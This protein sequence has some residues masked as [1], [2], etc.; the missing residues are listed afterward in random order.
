M[1][2]RGDAVSR[3]RSQES[4]MNQ[5]VMDHW[6]TVKR[7]HQ[8][9]LD[10]DPSKRAAFVDELCGGDEALRREVHSLLTYATDAE[11]FLE[12][13]AVDIATSSSS[14]RHETTLVG[15]TVSHY[16]VLSMLGA[17]G[18]GEVY[19]ARD[20]RLDRTVA[21]KI[22]PG[23][24]AA[25]PERMQRFAREAKA[26]SAL[27]H[28]NVA[29]IY[30]VGESDGISFIVMEHVEGETLLP[31]ISR[32]MTPPE[33]VDIAVQAADAL[34]L[35]HAKGI[36]HRDIKPANLMLTHRGVV[37]VLDF[38][39]AKVARSDEGSLNGDWT[40][41]P[42]TAVGSVV[43]S[44]PYMSPEQIVGGDV[45]SRSDVFNL[46]VVIYQMA[47]GQ[48]PFSGSTRAELMDQILHAAPEPMMRLNPDLP[49][50]L[51]RITLKCLD[52]RRDDRYQSGRELLTD[53]WPLKRQLD[54][55]VARAMPDAV[56]L[57]LLRRSA[58]HPGAAAVAPA[59]ADDASITDVPRASEAL[60][61]VARGWAHLRSASF[62]ELPAAVSSF[63]AATVI[64]PTYAAAYA[65][66]AHAKIDQAN[67]RHVLVEAFGEAKAAALRAVALD[68][69]SADAQAALG[70]VMLV[71]EWDW[72]AAERSF[73]RAL[74][75]NP[76]HAEAYLH[77]GTLMEALGNL[78]RGFQLKLKGLE[79]DS[80][81]AL[82][83]VQIAGSFWFQRRY[84]D[85]IVW[86]NK[87]L[88]RN[89][90][91]L[92]ARG[93]LAAAYW[94]MGDLERARKLL[95]DRTQL[96]LGDEGLFLAVNCAQA[97]DLDAAF[98][99]LQRLIDTRDFAVIHLA[100][101]PEWDSLRADPRFNECLAR[102][103]L[104]PVL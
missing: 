23:A 72:I 37:K 28:P 84:D 57:E 104:R 66:L 12:Q 5:P 24:L 61:L 65:G 82:A 69:E 44:G 8:S 68:H 94:K 64:D 80:T 26:A 100:V 54:A 18:M 35:A 74:A 39:V 53:L 71:A 92:A 79:C 90:Q 21:L 101:A 43:G 86:A 93:E 103:K 60:E 67:D 52:K 76:N 32:R 20:S 73:Q 14:E 70:L 27:N 102:M 49:S 25:D 13:P 36:T 88:D 97:G 59:G 9:A 3:P 42:V 16:Q 15:R 89:P 29:T 7:I 91:H 75:I 33:V 96:D 34:D 19:L 38:G 17:G 62:F 40:V 6:T 51:E 98:E 47:T 10:V 48:L 41:E 56:R 11:S 78:E 83:H 50:E 4:D 45:D 77:Y 30:D 2:H 81:S 46:G 63:Q 99:H 95:S 58:S 87:A 1:V 22:L 55:N 85:V 31:R